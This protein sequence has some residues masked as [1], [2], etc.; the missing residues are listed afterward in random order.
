M[1]PDRGRGRGRRRTRRRRCGGGSAASAG[2]R[3]YVKSWQEL[4]DLADE[5]G[6]EMQQIVGVSRDEMEEKFM[7][8]AGM[9]G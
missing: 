4:E 8:M 9:I 2:R 5:H 7:H 3:R 6:I 1:A